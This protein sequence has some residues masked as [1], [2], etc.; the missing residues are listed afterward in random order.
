[1]RLDGQ[2]AVITGAAQ[3][4]GFEFARR[5][6]EE[7]ALVTLADIKPCSDKLGALRPEVRRRCRFCKTDVRR[8]EDAEHLMEEVVQRDG[9]IDILINNASVFSSRERQPFYELDQQD[10]EQS[11]SVNVLG[12][13]HCVKAVFPYMRSRRQGKVINVASDAVFKGLPMLLDYV[14]AKGAVVAMTRSLARE[15]GPYDVTVNAVAPGYTFHDDH[16]NWS[17]TRNEQVIGA[18]C[19]Q[20]TQTPP[21][22]SGVVLFLASGDGDFLTGQTIV[23]DGGE[24]MR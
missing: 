17:E 21:D 15:L 22:I 3:G 9:G 20:R 16:A 14:A 10:W 13:F 8:F 11:F 19:L 5:L 12:T 7:G 6:A 23:V 24:V 4:L 1:M 2:I 18:R